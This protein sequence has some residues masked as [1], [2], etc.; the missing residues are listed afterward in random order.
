MASLA[1]PMARFQSNKGDIVDVCSRVCMHASAQ[2][3]VLAYEENW[4][5]SQDELDQR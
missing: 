4:C 3:W 1:N 5:P 2:V